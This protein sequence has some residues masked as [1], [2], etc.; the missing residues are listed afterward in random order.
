MQSARKHAAP[1]SNTISGL[2]YD[3]FTVGITDAVAVATSATGTYAKLAAATAG[4]RPV[5]QRLDSPLMY[6]YFWAGSSDWYIGAS[7]TASGAAVKS[8][9]T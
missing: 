8:S 7:Y 9:G 3:S 4:A 6:L 2:C 1:S 5:Y